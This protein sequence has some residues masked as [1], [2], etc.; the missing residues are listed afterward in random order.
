[1]YSN[2]S[3]AVLFDGKL[4]GTGSVK[5]GFDFTIPTTLG[6]H[7]LGFEVR[8]EMGTRKQEVVILVE[9]AEADVEVTAAG[10]TW[11]GGPVFAARPREVH[12]PYQ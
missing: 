7:V 1:M 8:A 11:T 6:R 2:E 5:R 12:E 10:P 4:L 9:G 3:V